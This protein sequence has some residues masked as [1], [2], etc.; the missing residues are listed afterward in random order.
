M[1]TQVLVL[2]HCPPLL[3]AELQGKPHALV[4]LPDVAHAHQSGA[5]RQVLDAA[6]PRS[7]R[8]GVQAL[9][10]SDRT[11]ALLCLL[12]SQAVPQAKKW[13]YDHAS[14]TWSTLDT[15][16]AS[17][18][19]AAALAPTTAPVPVAAPAPA[20][21][22]RTAA[23]DQ[24]AAAAAPP[25]AAFLG[26]TPRSNSPADMSD[27]ALIKRAFVL[28][29]WEDTPEHQR[30]IQ[31]IE[32][33]A[34][35]RPSFVLEL[36]AKARRGGIKARELAT[37]LPRI[38]QAHG[39]AQAEQWIAQQTRGTHES[40][41]RH[42]HI[43]LRKLLERQHSQRQ[44]HAATAASGTPAYTSGIA[45]VELAPGE[46]HPNSL[47]HLP[48][49]KHWTVYID[50]TG[51]RFDDDARELALRDQTLGRLVALAVPAG[52]ELPPLPGFH[53]TDASATQ[54]D[55]VVQRLLQSPVGILGFTVQD[56]S[57]R[58]QYWLGHVQHLVRW[59]LLQLPAPTESDAPCQ[60]KV[61][62]EQRDDYR[63]DHDLH[64][65]QRVLE[66]E[67]RAL[68]P[69]RFAR[70]ALTLG[71]M[72]KQHPHN[73]YVD[74]LAYTWGSPSNASQDRYKKSAL[75]GHCLIETPTDTPHHLYQALSRQGR[76]N[77]RDWYA[78]CS[79]ASAAPEQGLLAR[80][81]QRIGADCSTGTHP[82]VA[83][84]SAYLAHV[85]QRLHS[86]DYRLGELGHALAWLERH[87]PQGQRLP[88]LL[89]LQLHSA[90]LAST[91]HQGK[92]DAQQLGKCLDLALQLRD[93]APELAC[94]VLLRLVSA[95]T[96]QFEFDALQGTVQDWLAQP[97]GGCGLALRGKLHSSL[98]QMHAFAG[99]SA[100]ALQAF[101]QAQECLQRLSDPAQ[102]QR[103]Q[104]QT[105]QYALI[106]RLDA[107][108]A[109]PGQPDPQQADAFVADLIAHLHQVGC[110]GDA[111]AISRSL[112]HSGQERR[113][114]HHLWLRA[115]VALPGH[116]T[117]AEARAAYLQQ[118]GQWQVEPDHPWP[119]ICAYRAWL[120]HDAGRSARAAQEMALAIGLCTEPGHGLTLRWMAEVLR[121][122]AQRL[123][124]ARHAPDPEQARTLQPGAAERTELHALLQA[125]LPQAP[126]Q[127][128]ASFADPGAAHT[129]W[130]HLARCL[131][132][133]FH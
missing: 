97:H 91:N 87:A 99:H 94:E 124:L 36:I 120:L 63:P 108:T 57:S 12:A 33:E 26:H 6:L 64:F 50:E 37:G 100:P 111:P 82:D 72:S 52:T 60:V 122:L 41:T 107:L 128:L 31:E 78:L 101:A 46:A 79:A 14:G 27:G 45:P 85:Q 35:G 133:N 115:L 76:L 71:F 51:E 105:Q 55:T 23:P 3:P 25:S 34:V 18:P 65:M 7:A 32:R 73:G 90:R 61:L 81:L 106:A 132:F 10:A 89:E 114:P 102:R 117:L 20:P 125:L 29:A 121:A 116:P 16:L 118:D 77:E 48:P 38:F 70:L 21:V 80:E 59:V 86:K 4:D 44:R 2:P 54:V 58:H 93:E 11:P 22:Q 13:F 113:Y 95:T 119:L 47:A 9:L 62:I 98:G 42:L 5:A 123:G 88:G 109:G 75:R 83:T 69:Q 112:A 110:K 129:P 92:A 96:N 56:R 8:P 103:E 28:S 53:G 126:H 39:Q 130:Q 30:Q 127:E 74:A 84:W 17:A 43:E 24:P 104:L 1:N 40:V 66:S 67:M 131:P 49:A 68:D 15:R 19:S